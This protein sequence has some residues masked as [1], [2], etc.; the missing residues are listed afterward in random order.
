MANSNYIMPVGTLDL[1]QVHGNYYLLADKELRKQ[2]EGW[3]SSGSLDPTSEDYDPNGFVSASAIIEALAFKL[4]KTTYETLY[5]ILHEKQIAFTASYNDLVDVPS[6]G[7]AIVDGTTLVFSG[8]S[9]GQEDYL[10]DQLNETAK[11]IGTGVIY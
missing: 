8:S 4:D 1:I 5:S 9:S 6:F 7:G 2:V 11:V 3:S 10:S